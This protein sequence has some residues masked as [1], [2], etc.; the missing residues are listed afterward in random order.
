MSVLEGLSDCQCSRLL[1][2]SK[3][4]IV[5]GRGIKA[6]GRD[7]QTRVFTILRARHGFTSKGN[8]QDTNEILCWSAYLSLPRLSLFVTRT[9][10]HY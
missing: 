3:R 4:D 5:A 10:I 6:S 9:S 7:L 2:C 1:R 8:N